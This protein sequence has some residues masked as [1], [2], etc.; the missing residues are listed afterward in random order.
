M[1]G[2]SAAPGAP[3]GRR[4][5]PG[6]RRV[7]PPAARRPR[8]RRGARRPGCPGARRAAGPALSTGSGVRTAPR[9]VRRRSRRPR[10]PGG[11]DEPGVWPLHVWRRPAR[12]RP[13]GDD[14]DGAR[15]GRPRTRR[16]RRL[17]RPSRCRAARRRY[18]GDARGGG[19]WPARLARAARRIRALRPRWCTSS[20]RP[21]PSGSPRGSACCR[22]PLVSRSSRRCTSTAGGR[23]G[24]GCPRPR[25][26]RSERGARFDRET[27]RLAPASAVL[28]TTNAGGTSFLRGVAQ[29]RPRRGHC[30]AGT[31]RSRL[32]RRRWARRSAR[33]ARGAGRRR[34]GRVLRVRPP[35][36]GTA[37]PDRGRGPAPRPA[38][39]VAP[40]RARR[41]HLARA[42]R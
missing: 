1:S 29:A 4:A 12:E 8:A 27:W 20:S 36:E 11:S 42:A 34:G 38:R 13:S 22:T 10:S 21:R 17:H 15:S 16:C 2:S 39:A 23:P 6:V 14:R 37:V 24:G 31:E 9:G 30:S 3:A 18:R 28:V 26:R 33:T 7:R 40:A 5:G 32:R 35:G 25:G 19:P 41:L